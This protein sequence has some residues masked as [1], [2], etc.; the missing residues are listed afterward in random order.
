MYNVIQ[1]T[2]SWHFVILIEKIKF[3]A[4]QRIGD[5]LKI[6]SHSVLENLKLELTEMKTKAICIN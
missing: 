3:F 1:L 2:I 4:Y 6:H 5:Y